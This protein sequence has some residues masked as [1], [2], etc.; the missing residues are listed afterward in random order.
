MRGLR[1]A[2]NQFRHLKGNHVLGVGIFI[3][4]LAVFGGFGLFNQSDKAFAANP[5]NDIVRGG[6]W[7]RDLASKC[8][9]DVKVIMDHYR[10]DC[11]L[12]GVVDGR[13]CK[14]GNIYVGN[15]IVAR[16]SQSIGRMQKS[17]DHA[18]SIGGKTYWEAPNSTAFAQ[19]CL[20]TFVKLDQNGS[21]VYAIIKACGNP[22]WSPEPVTEKP[23]E[24]EKPA[25][26]CDMLALQKI[27]RT[28]YRFT[29]TA[30]ASGGAKIIG[31]KFTLGDGSVKE[32]TGNVIEHTY[33]E[34]GNYI[35]YVVAKVEVD[36]KTIEASGANCSKKLTIAPPE[37]VSVCEIE[38]GK[39]VQ[40]D[41]NYDRSKYSEN[42]ADCETKVCDTKKKEIVTIRKNEFDSS[43]HSHDEKDCEEEQPVPM[44]PQTGAG[45]LVGAGLGIG[46]T[47]VAASYYVASRRDLL[48]ALLNR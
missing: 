9:G 39:T 41:K 14:D 16:N 12:T 18:I 42:Y 25:Y 19:E 22:L 32:S 47:I 48:S 44:L 33:A 15:R 45:D 29:A 40:V 37:K 10:I 43:R 13:A 36:G 27:D 5:D 28:K 4:G 24:K 7:N 21:F 38:T 26:K 17:G 11:N 23:P 1:N 46:G 8:T 6:I 2:L 30:T 3:L 31:Y 34:E 35:P 20:D